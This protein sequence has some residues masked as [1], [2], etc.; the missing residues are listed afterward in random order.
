MEDKKAGV[1]TRLDINVFQTFSYCI[2]IQWNPNFV[3]FILK[4][5]G[6]GKEGVKPCKLF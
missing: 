3:V 5:R 6:E 2:V 4:E 1:K